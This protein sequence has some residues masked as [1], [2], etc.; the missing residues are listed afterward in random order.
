MPSEIPTTSCAPCDA[1]GFCVLDGACLDYSPVRPVRTYVA[2]ILYDGIPVSIADLLRVLNRRDG[3]VTRYI[4][5]AHRLHAAKHLSDAG[6]ADILEI[7]S[8]Q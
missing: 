4:E 2:A 5:C 7:A 6:L 3:L 1:A 8:G